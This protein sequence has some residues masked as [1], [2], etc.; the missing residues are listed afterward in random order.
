[1]YTYMHMYLENEVSG[2]GDEDLGCRV[3]T[4][5]ISID[6]ISL[7]G[8]YALGIFRLRGLLGFWGFRCRVYRHKHPTF[9]RTCVGKAQ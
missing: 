8:V 6:P 3:R 2:L 7:F 1:M 5:L 9:L 4:L